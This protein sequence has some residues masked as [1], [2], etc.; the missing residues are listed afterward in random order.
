MD[1]FKVTQDQKIYLGEKEIT[2]CTGFKVIANAGD[3]P[4]VQLRVIVESA[5]IQNY[6]AIPMQTE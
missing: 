1:K 4:E 2:H 3:D 6:Q 5:D